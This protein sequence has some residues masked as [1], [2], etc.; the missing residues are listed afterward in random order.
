MYYFKNTI[1]YVYIKH[2][3]IFAS[4]IFASTIFASTR[5]YMLIYLIHDKDNLMDVHE[6]EMARLI[7]AE[8]SNL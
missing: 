1:G 5:D 2:S 3:T 8:I 4:T 6:L 7:D